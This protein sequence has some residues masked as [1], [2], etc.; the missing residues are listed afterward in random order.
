MALTSAE[1]EKRVDESGL[2]SREELRDL[3][4]QVGAADGEVLA[5][6]RVRQKKLTK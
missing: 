4:T 1:F 2:M 6:E 3:V 5:R